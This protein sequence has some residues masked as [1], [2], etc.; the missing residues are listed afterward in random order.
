[1]NILGKKIQSLVLKYK[2]RR[3][4]YPKR[5]IPFKDVKNAM[6]YFDSK[7]NFENQ[8]VNYSKK[9]CSYGIDCKILC[10]TQII[11]LADIDMRISYIK[12]SDINVMGNFNESKIANLLEKEYDILF[13]LRTSQ[14]TISNY[15][16][17]NIKAKYI[18]GCSNDIDDL[19]IIINSSGNIEVFIEN[20]INLLMKIQK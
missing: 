12:D 10:Q 19:D 1:M 7:D 9:I 6:I 16:R 20:S 3:L 11:D 2:T 8:I 4:N 18:V 14:D 15:I 5:I 17:R 13:D